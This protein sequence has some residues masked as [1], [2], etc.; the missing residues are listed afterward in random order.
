MNNYIK[1]V[2]F[3]TLLLCGHSYAQGIITTIAGGGAAGCF[4]FTGDD[5]PATDATFAHPL[6]VQVDDS[7]NLFIA[8]L[9]NFCIRKVNSAGIITT[10]AGIGGSFGYN[11]DGIPATDAQLH[12]PFSIAVDHKG[13]LYIADAGNNRIRKVDTA[14][15]ITTIAGSG[16]SGYGGDDSSAVLCKITYPGGVAVDIDGNVYI[17]DGSNNRIR[18]V[19]T[20][21]IITTICGTGVAGFSG[22]SGLATLANINNPFKIAVDSARNIYFSDNGNNR[23]RKINSLGIITTIAGNGIYGGSG[24]GGPGINA[25]LNGPEGVSIDYSGNCYI[26]DPQ[27]FRVRKINSAGI[28]LN[29]AGTGVPGFSGDNG[30]PLLAELADPTGVAVDT[31]GNVYISDQGTNRIRVIRHTVDVPNINN[32]DNAINIYPNPCKGHSMIRYN[33]AKEGA[34]SIAIY[35]VTGRIVQRAKGTTNQA[36]AITLDVPAGVYYLSVR[37]DTD[38]QTKKLIVE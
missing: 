35:D 19:D 25:E 8:D 38:I 27:N 26:A 7:G 29:V 16:I 14:G 3:F 1:Y 9:D 6:D 37:S 34:L 23:V 18:R 11:G 21:G 5:G 2:F 4:C 22:D 33:S 13:N 31:G 24:D 17:G 12:D 36:I 32:T 30:P 10:V 28:I 20:S 15:I